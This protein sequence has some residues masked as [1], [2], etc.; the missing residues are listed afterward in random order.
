MELQQ[1]LDEA[2]TKFTE[3]LASRLFNV[4]DCLW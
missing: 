3:V 4:Q 1:R 2:R